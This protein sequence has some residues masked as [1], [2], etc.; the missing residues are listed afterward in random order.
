MKDKQVDGWAEGW[1]KTLSDNKQKENE[2]RTVHRYRQSK[3]LT[4]S[5]DNRAVM[6]SL[7]QD[8]KAYFPEFSGAHTPA[9]S[10]S[11]LT[12]ALSLLPS[13]TIAPFLS[14]LF[15][16]P[17]LMKGGLTHWWRP[18]FTPSD[19]EYSPTTIVNLS[20]CMWELEWRE[21]KHNLHVSSDGW[22][23]ATSGSCVL[24][25]LELDLQSR[26]WLCLNLPTQHQSDWQC[27]GG[28]MWEPYLAAS[29]PSIHVS[30]VITPA[31]VSRLDAQGLS[32]STKVEAHTL[33][34]IQSCV[35]WTSMMNRII[36]T[37]MI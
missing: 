15:A 10:L 31:V 1:I 33:P 23:Q 11:L 2:V 5:H 13:F 36:S 28:E 7:P 35:I 25:S 18:S 9:A 30:S 6:W 32:T 24:I 26:A 3:P 29:F 20:A 17:L 34:N 21:A 19:E 22:D 16:N 12:S 37:T 8:T 4:W 14:K 27:P